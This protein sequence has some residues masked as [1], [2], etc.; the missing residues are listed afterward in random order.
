MLLAVFVHASGAQ[1]DGDPASD[2]LLVSN[3]FYPF[4]LP[5]SAQLRRKLDTETALA[6]R[7]G[8]PVKVALIGAPSDLGAIP[9]LFGKPQTYA[10]F[11]DFEIAYRPL[12][13]VMG[14]GY[15]VA[16]IGGPVK[17]VLSR[18]AAP[19]GGSGD[20][21]A[22]SAVAAVASLARAVGHPLPGFSDSVAAAAGSGLLLPALVAAVGAVLL[23]VLASVI[24]RRRRDRVAIA[25]TRE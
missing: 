11:L 13:V 23:L 20:A 9:E 17:D 12:L 22:R 19:S 5:V 4:S 18:L 25:S 14:G 24:A 10:R 7:E 6:R 2:V 16:G 15:G 3:V 8:F 21:L 1:G